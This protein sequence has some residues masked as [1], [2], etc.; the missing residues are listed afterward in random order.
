MN[1][2]DWNETEMNYEIK[3][4][5][6]TQLNKT[7]LTGMKMEQKPNLANKGKSNEKK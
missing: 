6:Q 2:V 7:K 4:M 3:Q 1:E 5:R